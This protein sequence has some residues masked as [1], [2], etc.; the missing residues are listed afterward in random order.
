MMESARGNQSSIDVPGPTN[1][2][3]L[4]R[5][6]SRRTGDLDRRTEVDWAARV[7]YGSPLKEGSH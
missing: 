7:G 1:G 2:V 5:V 3:A 6:G 4:A